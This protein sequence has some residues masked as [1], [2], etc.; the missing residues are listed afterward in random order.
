MR[1]PSYKKVPL[2]VQSC[3]LDE[4]SLIKHKDKIIGFVCKIISSGDFQYYVTT[5]GNI[6]SV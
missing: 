1:G 3:P 5:R 2:V 6:I 4:E